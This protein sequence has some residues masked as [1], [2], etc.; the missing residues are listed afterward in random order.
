MAEP[1]LISNDLI[2]KVEKLYVE[3][4]FTSADEIAIFLDI[5]VE[6]VKKIFEILHLSTLNTNKYMSSNEAEDVE[7]SLSTKN[8]RISY[9]QKYWKMMDELIDIA[10]WEYSSHP[11]EKAASVVNSFVG[12]ASNLIQ[13]LDKYDD[14]EKTAK[15]LIVGVVDPFSS[16]VLRLFVDELKDTILSE[17]PVYLNEE[18]MAKMKEK[19]ELCLKRI[20]TRFSDELKIT[21]SRISDLMGVPLLEK[22]KEFTED[23]QA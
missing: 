7:A 13:Q 23:E 12:T 15:D 14:N 21:K 4:T 5:P 19:T 16:A 6:V 11:D 9:L 17:L 8:D 20:G 10:Q 3:G 1:D 2:K 18:A 22:T